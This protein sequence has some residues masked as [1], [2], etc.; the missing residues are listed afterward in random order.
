MP[1]FILWLTYYANSRAVP[2][3]TP[4][5]SAPIL[6]VSIMNTVVNETDPLYHT[7]QAQEKNDQEINR[8]AGLILRSEP[9]ELRILRSTPDSIAQEDFDH[10]E[11][12]F[13][14]A[15]QALG[16]QTTFLYPS[17]ES[18]NHTGTLPYAHSLAVESVGTRIKTIMQAL[19]RMGIRILNWIKSI[20]ERVDRVI[21]GTYGRARKAKKLLEANARSIHV[22]EV[23]V[24][25]VRELYDNGNRVT[26]NQELEALPGQLKRLLNVSMEDSARTVEAFKTLFL[27]S[28]AQRERVMAPVISNTDLKQIS[29][30]VEEGEMSRTYSLG[31]GIKGNRLQIRRPFIEKPDFDP[32]GYAARV[33]TQKSGKVPR[34]V[35]TLDVNAAINICT[36]IMDVI[37]E[38][39]NTRKRFADMEKNI[40]AIVE[41]EPKPGE[42]ESSE[43]TERRRDLMAISKLLMGELGTVYKFIYISTRDLMDFIDVLLTNPRKLS[44]GKEK[45][46]QTKQEAKAA[47]KV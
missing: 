17:M 20:L 3:G 28:T 32:Q 12:Q 11:R 26:T 47:A 46:I 16:I 7:F 18:I 39:R 1:S 45:R 27:D 8:I 41:S 40:K 33:I 9:T 43:F 5:M 19:R 15:D 22:R 31:F 13:V 37:D 14:E 35:E 21:E 2:D 10:I 6:K 38:I 29:A 36:N 4:F 30:K 44:T 24:E 23:S 42:N 34:K 25:W